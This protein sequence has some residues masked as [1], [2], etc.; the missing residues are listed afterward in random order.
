MQTDS[1]SMSIDP[2][3]VTGESGWGKWPGI[4]EAWKLWQ[5]CGWL[6]NVPITD[7]VVQMLSCHK[8]RNW[9][10]FC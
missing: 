7:D 1:L 6:E 3:D 10:L 5:F 9:A 8:L 2:T 4:R